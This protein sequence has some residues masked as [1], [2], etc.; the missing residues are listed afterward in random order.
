MIIALTL[1]GALILLDKY[2]IGEFGLSQPV[3]SGIILGAVFGDIKSGIL[4]GSALQLIFLTGLPIGRDIPPDAQG[5][6]VAGCGA[7]F[8]LLGSNSPKTALFV[9]VI[10]G[11][12]SGV[13][14]IAL[15]IWVRQ[16]N[17]K[18][19]YRFMRSEENLV[20]YHLAG[21]ATSFLRGIILLLPVFL[22]ASL[23]H[24]RYESITLNLTLFIALIVGTGMAN[25]I[26]LFMKKKN[27]SYF[28]LGLVCSL[29]LLVF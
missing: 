12:L 17:E 25:G 11:L 9:A 10:L 16:E 13:Y 20:L 29:I 26:L 28:V 15:E 24:I 27:L 21:I 19:F 23:I 14:G 1:L 6:G 2:A 4:L 5:A 22:V 18:L 7:Y 8:I 3:I